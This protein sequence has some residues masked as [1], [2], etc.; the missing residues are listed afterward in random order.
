MIA[1]A[2]ALVIFI[3]QRHAA[4]LFPINSLNTMSQPLAYELLSPQRQAANLIHC[5]HSLLDFPTPEPVSNL[6]L[7]LV[8]KVPYVCSLFLSLHL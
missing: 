2:S 8:Y 1:F 4:L 5:P 7:G 6:A 3:T